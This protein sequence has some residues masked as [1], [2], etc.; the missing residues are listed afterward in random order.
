MV[1][2]RKESKEMRSVPLHKH[3]PKKDQHRTL[4]LHCLVSY[5]QTC[6]TVLPEDDSFKYYL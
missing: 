1:P 3:T 4:Q 5:S 2:E 6:N